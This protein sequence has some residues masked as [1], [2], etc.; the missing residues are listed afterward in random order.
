MFET[1]GTL[2]E[3]VLKE[4]KKHA[5]KPKR[6]RFFLIYSIIF[7]L[8]GIVYIILALLSSNNNF[9]VYGIAFLSFAII[10]IRFITYFENRFKKINMKILE[11]ITDTKELKFKNYFDEYGV[12]VNNLTTSAKVKIKYEYFVSIIETSSMYFLLTEGN[13]YAI[14]FKDC[15]ENEQLNVFKEFIREKC[16]SIR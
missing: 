1:Y 16:S 14:V 2:D 15:L 7:G 10:A 9:I 5:M 11:E 3:N 6:K 4:L 13:Q 8:L 12:V